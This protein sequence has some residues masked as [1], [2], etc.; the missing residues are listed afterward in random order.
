MYVAVF[1]CTWYIFLSLLVLIAFLIWNKHRKCEDKIN[2]ISLFNITFQSTLYHCR[3]FVSLNLQFCFF[4]LSPIKLLLDFTASNTEHDWCRIRKNSHPSRAPEFNTPL[5][6]WGLSCSSF[7]LYVLCLLFSVCSLCV[8]WP[9]LS[10]SGLSVLDCPFCF[11][12]S[13]VVQL[14]YICRC[15][16]Y[17]QSVNLCTF[18]AY[19]RVNLVF[20]LHFGLAT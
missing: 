20:V 7:L 17:Y 8:L 9:M 10:V 19:D 12:V 6:W 5:F 1:D 13:F 11:L 15:H 14:Y 4:P 3:Y 2:I 16:Y 18:S